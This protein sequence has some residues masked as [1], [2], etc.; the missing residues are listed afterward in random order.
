MINQ[1]LQSVGQVEGVQVLKT[2]CRLEQM[3]TKA[4]HDV[5]GAAL[6]KGIIVEYEQI[7]IP[8]ALLAD[9]LRLYHMVLNLID[10]AVKYSPEN[11]QIQVRLQFTRGYVTL[12]V[13]DEGAGI[14]EEDIPYIFDKYYRGVQAQG[15]QQGAGVGLALVKAIVEAHEGDIEAQNVPSG[16]ALFVVKLPSRLRVGEVN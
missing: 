2:P 9:R 13:Q 12:Q 16:G 8:Y 1:L 15:K 11:R 5:E 14:P 6:S 4:I 3:I 7:G 10:N